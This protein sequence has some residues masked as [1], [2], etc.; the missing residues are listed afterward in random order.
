[1]ELKDTSNSCRFSAFSKTSENLTF[2]TW[3]GP[4]QLPDNTQICLLWRWKFTP[5]HCIDLES[6]K[7]Y[8]KKPLEKED[9]WLGVLFF[10]DAELEVSLALIVI[11][12][13]L[14]S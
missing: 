7:S 12:R 13:A 4:A 5:I 9:N 2:L 10:P 11:Y 14:G 1:M 6:S 8:K 3:V